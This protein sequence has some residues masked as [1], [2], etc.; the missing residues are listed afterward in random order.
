MDD[1]FLGYPIWTYDG[2]STK[3]ATTYNSDI[4]LHPVTSYPDPFLGGNNRLVLC[5]TYGDD[6]LPTGNKNACFIHLFL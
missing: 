2:S 5:E 4:F 3:Q 6:K 1:V